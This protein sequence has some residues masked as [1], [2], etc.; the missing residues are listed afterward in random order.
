MNRS[1]NGALIAGLALLCGAGSAA[2]AAV[3]GPAPEARPGFLLVRTIAG[4]SDTDVKALDA[5]AG[6]VETV[7]A[8]TLVPGLRCVR[9]AP[10][11]GGGD[12]A[13][14]KALRADPLVRYAEP[15]YIRHAQAQSTPYGI[16]M[17]QA[18]T[19]WAAAG[20][21]GTRGTGAV[22]AD[23]DT[24]LDLLHP[25]LPAPA[26]MQSFIDG[27][28][29]QD[30]HGHGTHTAGTI[31][32][33]DNTIGVVGVAPSATLIVGKVLSDGG[34]G[35]D[36][37]VA[38]GIDWAVANRAR[39]IS[40]SL[41]GSD[42]GQ[43]MHDSCDAALAA[44]VLVV[45]AAGNSN[46]SAPSYPAAWSSVL[47]VAAVSSTMARA[48]FSNFGPTI[49]LS[50]PGVSV[51]STYVSGLATW[52]AAG[53]IATPLTGSASG[54]VSGNAVYC[55]IGDSAAAFPPAVA[56]QIAHIR[57][58]TNSFQEK[59]QFAVDA[60][61][62]GVI[63]SNNVA[64]SFSGTLGQEFAIPVV[65][66]SQADG[67]NLQAADGVATTIN[68]AGN[69]T[70]GSLSGTSMAC[71]HVSGVAALLFA[72]RPTSTPAQVRSAMEQTAMDLGDPGRDDLFGWGLVQA[73]AAMGNLLAQIPCP[74]DYDGAVG[75]SVQD[76]FAFL[77]DWFAGTIRSD[78]NGVGG[79]TTQDI[80]DFLN[81]WFAGCP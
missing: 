32:A 59:A 63:I 4:A 61:A 29:V 72:A 25:D 11:G 10:G 42:D 69:H 45:A 24:G 19:V 53:H 60:G 56:G 77:N 15:D 33:L 47:S 52:S 31:C 67:D 41:G 71:P 28:A 1:S 81:A 2:H 18:P 20:P 8:S 68:T 13:A 38:A 55:G 23:L 62:V 76:I 16:T 27:Q 12:A 74:A 35:P 70:Y 75:L 34:S 30:G 44:G 79:L 48:S 39:V 57:R 78:F 14:L 51:T 21:G 73:S 66:I 40:M 49:S 22:V 37:S 46:S 5:R 65:G 7:W 54:V 43:A 26:T 64:G 3:S 58:G 50:A 6:I 36:S 80:F 17:V 9:L